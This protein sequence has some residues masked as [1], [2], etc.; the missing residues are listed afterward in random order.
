M[1]PLEGS[2]VFH[3]L[4]VFVQ[5]DQKGC[6]LFPNGE[7]AG[8]R[9]KGRT[10]NRDVFDLL[11]RQCLDTHRVGSQDEIDSLLFQGQESVQKGWK[12]GGRLR[13]T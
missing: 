11:L 2:I 9:E 10:D 12:K 6:L 5:Q 4:Q 7:T 8:G 3:L 13:E 1:D